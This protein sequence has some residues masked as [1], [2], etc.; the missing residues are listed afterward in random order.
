MNHDERGQ[1]DEKLVDVMRRS[2]AAPKMDPARA[3]AF[4]KGLRRRQH[5]RE[6]VQTGAGLL[7]I[8]AF[9]AAALW[10]AA[11][12]QE[13]PQEAAAVGPVANIGPDTDESRDDVPAM[14]VEE[15]ARLMREVALLAQDPLA[16]DMG[17]MPEDYQILMS[18]VVQ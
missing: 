3:A 18:L 8:A 12:P 6:Q 9:V 2:Y 17:Y 14:T 5:R 7:V 1:G 16:E 11:I 15:R 10:W 13:P 4:N